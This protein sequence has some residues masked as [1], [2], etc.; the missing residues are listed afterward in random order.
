MPDLASR[1]LLH[2]LTEHYCRF[3]WTP[4]VITF[5]DNWACQHYGINDYY[6]SDPNDGKTFTHQLE[7][8]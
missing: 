2:K 1:S 6:P 5:W 4:N 3:L 8:Q 7:E